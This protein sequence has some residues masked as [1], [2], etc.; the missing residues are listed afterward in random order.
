[1]AAKTVLIT[2]CN[3]GIGLA[4]TEHY[5]KQGWKVIASTRSVEKTSQE[6]KD[7]APWKLI[8]IDTSDEQSILS[9]A[10]ALKDTPIDLLINNAGILEHKDLESTTKEDLM[11]QFEVNAVGPFLTTR[12]FLPNLR[13]AVKAN[14]SAFVV[15]TTSRMGSITDNSSGGFYGYRASKTALNMITSSL[16]IDLKNEKIGCLLVHPGYVATEMVFNKGNVTPKESVANLTKIIE[17]ATLEDSAKVF[18][19]EGYVLPW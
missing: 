4:F 17:N 8:P 7:L 2:G 6:L 16:A 12:A 13:S 15:Q 14:G 10:E 1:M 18:H 9:A 19:F 5:V 11:R 3:R